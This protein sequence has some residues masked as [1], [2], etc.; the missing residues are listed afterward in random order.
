MDLRGLEGIQ[1]RGFSDREIQ[2]LQHRHENIQRVSK[3]KP[4]EKAPDH[5]EDNHHCASNDQLEKSVQKEVNKQ[6]SSPP[7][8]VAKDE[9]DSVEQYVSYMHT[10]EDYHC[11]GACL[12]PR[13]AYPYFT[14][15]FLVVR[16]VC[17]RDC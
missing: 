7:L 15:L 10:L 17:V 9:P 12:V 4:D 2:Q 3:A 16:R 6:T 11:D 13:P 5:H 14:L 8:D 1:W